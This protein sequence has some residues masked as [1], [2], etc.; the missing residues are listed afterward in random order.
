MSLLAFCCAIIASIGFGCVPNVPLPAQPD[1]IAA[2]D[3]T[4]NPTRV[5]MGN[6]P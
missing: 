5:F 3:T 4:I 6:T 2:T 1:T